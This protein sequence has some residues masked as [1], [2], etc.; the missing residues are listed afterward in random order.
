MLRS[1]SHGE[2]TLSKTAVNQTVRGVNLHLHIWLH[3]FSGFK[4]ITFLLYMISIFSLSLF[5]ISHMIL[6]RKMIFIR[7]FDLFCQDIV[8]ACGLGPLGYTFHVWEILRSTLVVFIF[9]TFKG[10]Q[11]CGKICFDFLSPLLIV[12]LL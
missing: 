4:K 2:W 10:C 9:M 8:P 11:W 3:H 5:C 12:I 1:L 6:K 7:C